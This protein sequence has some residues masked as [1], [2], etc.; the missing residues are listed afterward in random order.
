MG[1]AF[2][3][4][5]FSATI[6]ESGGIET[7]KEV[8]TRAE[9]DRRDRQLHLV[10]ES[11]AQVPRDRRDAAHAPRAGGS[12]LGPAPQPSIGTA[13]RWTRS[14]AVVGLPGP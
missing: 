1:R 12:W 7:G 10:D 5:M 9:Q 3:G 14:R 11:G 8:F 4:D 6:A 2:A 13:K